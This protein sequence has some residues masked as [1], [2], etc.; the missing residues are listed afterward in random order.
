MYFNMWNNENYILRW[1]FLWFLL[2]LIIFIVIKILIQAYRKYKLA[3][4]KKREKLAIIDIIKSQTDEEKKFYQL[5]DILEL[6]S[7]YKIENFI[8]INNK[9]ILDLIKEKRYSVIN[10]MIY[11]KIMNNND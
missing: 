3:Y 6:N 7:S 11:N 9:E 1:F 5:K 10:N 8:G 2:F 4:N